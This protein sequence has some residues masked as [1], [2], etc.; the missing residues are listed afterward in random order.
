MKNIKVKNEKAITL[1]A[2]IITIIILVILAAVSIRAITNMAIVGHAINGTQDYAR[3]SVAEQ[4]QMREATIKTMIAEY[5]LKNIL[6]GVNLKSYLEGQGYD[7]TDNGDGT[8]SIE[9]DGY[10]ITIDEENLSYTSEKATKMVRITFLKDGNKTSVVAPNDTITVSLKFGEDIDLSNTKYLYTNSSSVT[11][12]QITTS[13][14]SNSN[15]EQTIT[16]GLS[17]STIETKYFYLLVAYKDGTESEQ[18]V[19]SLQVGTP[20]TS[21]KIYKDGQEATSA[22]TTMTGETLKGTKSLTLHA[23]VAPDNASD[24]TVTW[25]SS[26]TDVATVTSAGVVT[27]QNVETAGTV[28]I[29]A[30]ANGGANQTA[31]CQITVTP[32]PTA[33][34]AFTQDGVD[35][36]WEDVHNMAGIISGMQGIDRTSYEVTITNYNNTGKN[37]YLSTRDN[38]TTGYTNEFNLVGKITMY[39]QEI[40]YTYKVRI[41]GFN[42]DTLSSTGPSYM[43]YTNGGSKAGITFQFT[44]FF[45]WNGTQ[46]NRPMNSTSS[47]YSDGKKNNSG[48]WGASGMQRDLNSTDTLARLT[49][50]AYIKT[51]DKKY[52]QTYNQTTAPTTYSQDK[53]WLLACSEIWPEEEGTTDPRYG[54]AKWAESNGQYKWYADNVTNRASAGADTDLIKNQSTY[55]ANTNYGDSTAFGWWLRSAYYNDK[56][57]FCGITTNGYARF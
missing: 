31:T 6:D 45:R 40:D 50:N 51:V 22:V 34:Y 9:I 48:G 3:A 39:N 42:T 26:D 43:A 27:A 55:G 44:N 57:Y 35:Y 8:L 1:I 41:I 29:T 10:T 4:A 30:T 32:K 18:K 15:Q 56:S 47:P 33:T 38:A 5:K 24:K 23:V 17:T 28:T 36:T 7:V 25:E 16:S 49:N 2:L 21:I 53:L 54:H 46:E 20:V 52:I 11:N 13:L 19:A 14:P 12:E 37:V